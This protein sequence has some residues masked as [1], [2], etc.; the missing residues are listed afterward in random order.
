MEFK[1][2]ATL[3]IH[4]RLSCRA[5]LY[6][7]RGSVAVKMY[8]HLIV[9]LNVEGLELIS[10][11]MKSHRQPDQWIQLLAREPDEIVSANSAQGV[12]LVNQKPCGYSAEAALL[13]NRTRDWRSHNGTISPIDG[14]GRDPKSDTLRP[15]VGNGNYPTTPAPQ[16]NEVDRLCLHPSNSKS[17]YDS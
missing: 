8:C 4:G 11:S 5:Q 6:V 12:V 1:E 14:H 16:T 17:Y 10:T 13:V 2:Q 3:S 9:P 7:G 15:M